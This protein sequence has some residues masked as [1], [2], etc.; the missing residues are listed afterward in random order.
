L[1][2]YLMENNQADGD[3]EAWS[4]NAWNKIKP[5]NGLMF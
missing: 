5:D 1:L 4:V 2:D 3:W